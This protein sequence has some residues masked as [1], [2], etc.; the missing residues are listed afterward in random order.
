MQKAVAR[1]VSAGVAV[2]GRYGLGYRGGESP[3]GPSGNEGHPP[4]VS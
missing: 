2:S 4:T 1:W 3:I